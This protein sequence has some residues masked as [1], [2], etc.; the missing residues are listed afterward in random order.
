MDAATLAADRYDIEGFA[1]AIGDIPVIDEPALVRLR[2]RDFFWFSPIL[3]AELQRKSA[4]LVVCPRDEADIVRIAGAAARHRVPVTVRGAGTGNYGQAVPLAGGIVL[5]MTGLTAIEWQRPGMVR[6]Q[7]GKKLVEL[8]QETRPG[9]WEQRMHPS[10]KRTATIGGF[11]AGGSGGVGSVTYGG[12]RE[13]G[14]ILGARIVTLEPEP[15]IIELRDDAAQKVC[16]AYGTNGIITAVEMATAPSYA[17]IDLIV[18]FDDLAGAL[19]AGYAA[20]LADGVV[21]KLLT[22]IGWPVPKYFKGFE[23]VCPNGRSLLAAMVAEPSLAPFE[24]MMKAHGGTVTYRAATEEG[25]GARPLYELTWNHTTLH[26]L[27]IDKHVTYLQSLFPADR[28]LAAIAE[29]EALLGDRAMAH[30]E[31]LRYNGTVT[32]IG[33]PLVRFTD[34]ASLRE[35][36]A[37]HIRHGVLIADPHVTSLEAGS[38]H[39]RADIDQ[40]GFKHEADPLGL[41]NPGK[42]TS[43][44]AR[45]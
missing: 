20:A 32:A 16:H 17:W 30:Y 37:L 8:D 18:T 39:M 45:G 33:L 35:L 44:V 21:K 31:F 1:S 43:F 34:A 28:L 6:V 40:L 15:R 36:I 29:I 12:L 5:D 42:M 10:T 14:N 38:G 11:V 24:A 19:Q 41:M 4:D 26:A 23:E 9:G 2:S 3:K 22:P 25:P 27:K 13:P 7:P